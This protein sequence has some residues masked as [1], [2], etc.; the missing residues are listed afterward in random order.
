MTA[1]QWQA[2]NRPISA[3]LLAARLLLQFVAQIEE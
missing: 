2:A 1:T 3:Y